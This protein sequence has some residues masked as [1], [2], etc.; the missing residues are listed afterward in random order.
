MKIS[1]YIKLLF[2]LFFTCNNSLK[3]TENAEQFTLKIAFVGDIDKPL[4]TLNFCGSCK[5]TFKLSNYNY[6]LNYSSYLELKKEIQQQN[7][8]VKENSSLTYIT[9]NIK[10]GYYLDKKSSLSFIAKAL[11]A[12]EYKNN[13]QLKNQLNLYF[14]VLNNR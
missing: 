3:T 2:L 6:T 7:P 11:N 14:R 9:L 10:E 1:L 4:P 5:E 13:K 8:T 12:T